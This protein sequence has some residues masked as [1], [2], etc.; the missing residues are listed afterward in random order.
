M[1]N[2]IKKSWTASNLN[3]WGENLIIFMQLRFHAIGF[4]NLMNIPKLYLETGI[5]KLYFR[6]SIPPFC[7][8]NNV[9]Q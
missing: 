2:L 7:K 5:R 9:P 6:K 4:L 1:P 3:G 8:V